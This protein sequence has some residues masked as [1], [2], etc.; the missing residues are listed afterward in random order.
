MR[1]YT[2]ILENH[3]LKIELNKYWLIKRLKMTNMTAHDFWQITVFVISLNVVHNQN[4]DIHLKNHSTI[5]MK[6]D[7]WL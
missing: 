1:D 4:T 3:Y 5:F 2:I 6:Y 7:N